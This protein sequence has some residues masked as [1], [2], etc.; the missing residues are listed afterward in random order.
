MP[1]CSRSVAAVGEGGCC[2]VGD[3]ISVTPGVRASVLS[4]GTVAVDLRAASTGV[5]DWMLF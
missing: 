2:V 3:A 1:G 4:G 5:H